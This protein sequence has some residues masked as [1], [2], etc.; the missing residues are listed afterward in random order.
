[1]FSPAPL[2]RA[3][4]RRAF[5][6]RSFLHQEQTTTQQPAYRNIKVQ[7]TLP[8]NGLTWNENSLPEGALPP[9]EVEARWREM[10][11]Q[12][13][14]DYRHHKIADAYSG[15]RVMVKNGNFNEAVRELD[16]ILI[17]NRVRATLY[18]NMRHEKKGVKRRRIHSEQW[19]KHF[20]AEVRKNVQ[21]VRE[22][23]RR[24]A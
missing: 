13:L 12:A 7:P 15:R 9:L 4:C 6:T 23:R 20:A 2:F 8:K 10:S 1:M 5:G 18:A 17:R 16:Q 22:I 21:V 24:G 19:R 14:S 3:V 11:Q